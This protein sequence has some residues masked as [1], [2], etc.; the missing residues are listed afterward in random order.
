MAFESIIVVLSIT[1]S[2]ESGRRSIKRKKEGRRQF[3]DDPQFLKL[4]AKKRLKFF[5]FG[6]LYNNFLVVQNNSRSSYFVD[7]HIEK[8]AKYWTFSASIKKSDVIDLH[9]L[10][11]IV[12]HLPKK[13]IFSIT[14]NFLFL[15]CYYSKFSLLLNGERVG[16]SF[17]TSLSICVVKWLTC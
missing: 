16:T 11:R 8:C 10:F 13:K 17:S 4:S 9:T 1:N 14:A 7:I 15:L 3:E 12:D 6:R 2:F 5:L